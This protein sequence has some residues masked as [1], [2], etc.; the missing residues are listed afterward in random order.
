MRLRIASAVVVVMLASGCAASTPRRPLDSAE[1]TALRS[2]ASL[3]VAVAKGSRLVA[4]GASSSV[5]GAL[6]VIGAVTG[7]ADILRGGNW[8]RT[9]GIE[10]PAWSVAHRLVENAPAQIGLSK[11]RAVPAMLEDEGPEAL[12]ASVAESHAVVLRTYNWV[13]AKGTGWA[14]EIA[15]SYHVLA[16]LVRVSDG[17]VL[18]NTECDVR[19]APA[20][21]ARWEENDGALLRSEHDRAADACSSQLLG[22][23][24][25]TI[26]EAETRH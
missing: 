8:V 14:P 3:P 21:M 5:L 2:E 16:R 22:R 20:T 11:A 26:R 23:L 1:V 24:A 4:R 6:P 10:D 12:R 25:E 18:W 9:Y 13:I 17:T 15:L 19:T 7:A